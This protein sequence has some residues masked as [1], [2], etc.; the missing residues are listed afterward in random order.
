MC[1]VCVRDRESGVF[2]SRCAARR[3]RRRA[4][5]CA[6]PTTHP[7]VGDVAVL[8]EALLHDGAHLLDRH[9]LVEVHG[10]V[11]KGDAAANLCEGMGRVCVCSEPLQ[12]LARLLTQRPQPE[13]Q[14]HAL[15][16]SKTCAPCR[17]TSPGAGASTQPP[18]PGAPWFAAAAV[19]LFKARL[20]ADKG[21]SQS[22]VFAGNDACKGCALSEPTPLL[23]SVCQTCDCRLATAGC[24][25]VEHV[26][27]AINQVSSRRGR[28]WSARLLCPRSKQKLL[29][30]K[31]PRLLLPPPSDTLLLLEESAQS[32]HT[33]QFTC[34]LSLRRC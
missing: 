21:S 22:W 19:V 16:R 14:P 3:C 30:S 2:V 20:R 1:C 4:P 18:A 6:S 5:R 32:A 29:T 27:V 9:D 8:L 24:N 28:G 11:D 34:R 15:P 17:Q 26:C 33:R 12:P 31:L 10:L 23:R 25:T 13:T 7:R